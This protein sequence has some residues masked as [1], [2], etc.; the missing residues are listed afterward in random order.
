MPHFAIF[1][2]FIS[3]DNG[4]L[5]A[6]FLP[7]KNKKTAL[8]IGLF[9]VQVIIKK[10]IRAATLVGSFVFVITEGINFSYKEFSKNI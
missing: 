6:P 10:T 7:L 2:F 3:A 5:F 9:D 4:I 1:L 8:L